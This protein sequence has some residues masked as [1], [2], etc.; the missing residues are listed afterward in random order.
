MLLSI[1]RDR[2]YRKGVIEPLTAGLLTAIMIAVSITVF[3]WGEPFLRK[4][5]VISVLENSEKFMNQLSE[6]IK[7][8]VNNQPGSRSAVEMPSPP[9]PAIKMTLLFDGTFKIFS[10]EVSDTA[11]TIYSPGGLISLSKNACTPEEG[12][13]NEDEPQTICVRSDKVGENYVTTYTLKFIQLNTE[14]VQSYKIDLTGTSNTVGEGHSIR[15]D[16]RGTKTE[17]I[18][19]KEVLKT[20]IGV[21]IR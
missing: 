9:S 18:D 10:L 16:N 3:V 15:L 19:G 11:G 21:E 2:R 17:S 13:A 12:I 14:G 20:K 4:S 1:L 8:V 5:E 6:K 7:D